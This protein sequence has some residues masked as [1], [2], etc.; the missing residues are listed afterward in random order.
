MNQPVEVSSVRTQFQ[1]WLG[2][3]GNETVQMVVRFG[4]GPL[5]PY[6][7]RRPVESVI[8]K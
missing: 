8:L 1:S 4:Y 5:A 7:L 6:S 3:H 2:L